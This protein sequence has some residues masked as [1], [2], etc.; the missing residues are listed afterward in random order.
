MKPHEIIEIAPGYPPA[1]IRWYLGKTAPSRKGIFFAILLFLVG[2]AG[3]FFSTLIDLAYSHEV[4]WRTA[5]IYLAPVY[6]PREQIAYPLS[7]RPLDARL[8]TDDRGLDMLAGIATVPGSE[9]APRREMLFALDLASE[10]LQIPLLS[11]RLPEPGQ[12]EVLAGDLASPEPFT[13]NGI[14]FTVTGRLHP[15]ASG[16]ICSYLLPDRSAFA[17][18]FDNADPEVFQG[19]FIP[20]NGLMIP[21]PPSGKVRHPVASETDADELP[22]KETDAVIAVPAVIGGVLRTHDYAARC[23]FLSMLL[24]ALGGSLF[25]IKLFRRFHLQERRLFAPVFGAMEQH[26][27]FFM[28]M[29]LLLYGAFFLSM[30]SAIS[31]P[32]MGYE[33]KRYTMDIFSDGSLEYIGSAYDKGNILQATWATFYNNYIEQTLVMTFALSLILPLGVLKNIASFFIVGG[34]MSPLWVGTA[35]VLIL[36]CLTMVVELEAYIIAC[37]FVL[38]WSALLLRGIR[39]RQVSAAIRKGSWLLFNAALLTAVILA[40][41]ALYEAVTLIHLFS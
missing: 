20:E 11:G 7:A 33:L 24:C 31:N 37:F 41:A 23:S 32:L 38:L 8:W 22:G 14:T 19:V 34:A 3:L 15:A 2:I 13:I 12:A 1:E 27:R 35:A 30:Y 17:E 21:E 5:A 39:K 36:H 25:F 4:P 10:T 40:A 16:F 28:L 29:H 6:V 18:L 26:R 9:T